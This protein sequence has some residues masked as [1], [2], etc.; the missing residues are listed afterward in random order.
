MEGRR[1]VGHPPIGWRFKQVDLEYR[2]IRILLRSRCDDEDL[3]HKV[4][5]PILPRKASSEIIR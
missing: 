1:R 2:K 5:D 3:V 4:T